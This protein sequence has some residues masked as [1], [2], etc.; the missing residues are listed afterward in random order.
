MHICQC[1]SALLSY[2]SILSYA[3]RASFILSSHHLQ[4]TDLSS[5]VPSDPYLHTNLSPASVS[6]LTLT[7]TQSKHDP[8]SPSQRPQDHHRSHKRHLLLTS[9]AAIRNL[10]S[11]VHVPVS[12]HVP[13]HRKQ[14]FYHYLLSQYQLQKNLETSR[15][16]NDPPTQDLL[17]SDS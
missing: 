15:L 2:T 8:R 10:H 17:E 7:R 14:A 3:S 13:V 6:S 9:S 4:H 5:A 16:R 11:S 12:I 1:A